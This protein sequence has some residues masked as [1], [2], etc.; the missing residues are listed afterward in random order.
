MPIAAV[1]YKNTMMHLVTDTNKHTEA[2]QKHVYKEV[3]PD[4]TGMTLKDAVYLLENS[5]MHVR[6]LGK[7]RVQAQSVPA[8]TRLLKGQN[9]LLQLS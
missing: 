2:Q 8:G 3:M 1:D 6:I 7:G 5:G 9:I 4:V